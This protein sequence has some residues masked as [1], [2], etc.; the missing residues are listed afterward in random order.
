VT[1]R[2][3][4]ALLS[5]TGTTLVHEAEV[6]PADGGES[7][8][9]PPITAAAGVLLRHAIVTDDGQR[10]D[11]SPQAPWLVRTDGTV[12]RLPFALGVSP[13]LAMSGDRWL[14]PGLDT[15]WRDD[16]DEPFGV[17][18]ATGRIEPLL[19]GGRPVPASRMLAEATPEL[20]AALH[21]IDPER[22]VPWEAVAARVDLVSDELA[23]AIEVDADEHAK[24]LL[25][26]RLPFAGGAPARVVARFES[27]PSSQLAIAP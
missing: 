3:R 25:A 10:F 21:T 19:I 5:E 8:L 20:L 13:L 18:D 23:I 1:P 11:E 16:Y 12:N 26:V 2:R 17:L 14:L 4:L 7:L 6:S 27:T 22:D 9:W 15:V 24:T